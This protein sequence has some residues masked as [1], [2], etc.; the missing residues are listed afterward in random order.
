MFM[1]LA[2]FRLVLGNGDTCTIEDNK[3]STGS[4]LVDGANEALLEVITT[5]LFI[6]EDGAIPVVRLFWG[7]FSNHSPRVVGS[8]LIN[9]E[10]L[11]LGVPINAVVVEFEGVSHFWRE[12]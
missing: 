12:K 7:C 6:L 10:L 2:K 9:L 11:G 8:T 4:S 5:P 1:K 3:A